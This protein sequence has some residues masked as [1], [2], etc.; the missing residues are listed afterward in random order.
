[1]ISSFWSEKRVKTCHWICLFFWN[2]LLMRSLNTDRAPPGVIRQ[3]TKAMFMGWWAK[4]NGIGYMSQVIC[5]M[6]VLHVTWN[7][8]HAT[9]LRQ[10]DTT[11]LV[12]N[13]KPRSLRRK[14]LA[15]A[16][17]KDI[18][19]SGFMLFF[20]L[21]KR[22][23]RKY[24]EIISSNLSSDLSCLDSLIAIW[25]II[26]RRKHLFFRDLKCYDRELLSIITK[27]PRPI[28]KIYWENMTTK[29]HIK[30]S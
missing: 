28:Q 17:Q 16:S 20:C 18:T 10:Y 8:Q 21:W 12:R 7:I 26:Q 15:T 4:I 14:F 19:P 3:W 13:F 24:L 25:S 9:F 2:S 22:Q 5:Y 6:I 11:I 23:R 29:R 27:W 1:M 30:K